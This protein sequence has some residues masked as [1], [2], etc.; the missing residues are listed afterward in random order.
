M[1]KNNIKK[2]YSNGEITVVW[3][4]SKCSH[5]A[6]CVKHLS[7]VFQPQSHPWIKI[8]NATTAEIV[9]TVAKCPSGALSIKETVE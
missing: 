6:N 4:S 7:S 9:A 1:D 5:S 8:D 3:Q 2:E